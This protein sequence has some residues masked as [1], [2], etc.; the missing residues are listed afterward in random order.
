MQIPASFHRY[1]S[2]PNVA[3]LG[4]ILEIPKS[5]TGMRCR[6]ISV[7]PAHEVPVEILKSLVVFHIYHAAD[8]IP[9]S[10]NIRDGRMGGI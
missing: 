6:D 5:I 7:P 4:L 2:S 3:A 10:T 8:E 9:F 1:F